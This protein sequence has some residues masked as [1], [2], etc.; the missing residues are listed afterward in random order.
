MK[1]L[2]ILTDTFQSSDLLF[3]LSVMIIGA[4]IFPL[5]AISQALVKKIDLT[6][7]VIFG[8]FSP[9]LFGIIE[10]ALQTSIIF[11]S[12]PMLPIEYR[13]PT[14]FQG[15]A[16]TVGLVLFSVIITI[17]QIFLTGITTTIAQKRRESQS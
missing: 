11:D 1:L 6:P 15:V 13:M 16:T 17:P 8:A 7:L 14:L 2:M 4:L 10:F 5:L 12:V 3:P 9:L